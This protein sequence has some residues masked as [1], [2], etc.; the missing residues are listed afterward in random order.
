MERRGGQND[1]GI[2]LA[3]GVSIGTLRF[4][5]LGGTGHDGNNVGLLAGSVLL[6]PV[7]FLQNSGEHLL[8]AAAGGDILLKLRI[9]VLHKLNPGRAAGAKME[10][11]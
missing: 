2:F 9:L 6:I 4:H 5:L 7:V 8:G 10:A 11:A 1:V 3:V